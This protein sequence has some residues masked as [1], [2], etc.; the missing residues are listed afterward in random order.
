MLQEQ[1][2]TEIMTRF[3]KV[4]N[5]SEEDLVFPD[6]TQTVSEDIDEDV[7]VL[8][9]AAELVISTQFGSTSM[10][11][12]KL[13]IGF[14]KA[15]RLMDL[16]EE[17][18]IVGPSKGSKARD[19]LVKTSELQNALELLRHGASI[20]VSSAALNGHPEVAQ[21]E[22]ESPVDRISQIN[23]NYLRSSVSNNYRQ[24]RIQQVERILSDSQNN[25]TKF[26]FSILRRRER[27][28]EWNPNGLDIPLVPPTE[29]L[30][31]KPKSGLF[32]KKRLKAYEEV[33][34]STEYQYKIELKKYQDNESKRIA[35]LKKYI[36]EWERAK[37]KEHREVEEY[38]RALDAFQCSVR[39]G[40]RDAV[41]AFFSLLLLSAVY[42]RDIKVGH[43]VGYDPRIK[44]LCVEYLFPSI[45][46]VLPVKKNKYIKNNDSI[47][48]LREN[49]VFLKEMYSSVIAQI[50]LRVIDEIFRSDGYHNVETVAFNGV[51]H[52]TSPSTG[53][54][55]TAY[56]VS[57]ETTKAVFRE[58]DLRK[59][60]PTEALS[61]LYASVVSNP[62]ESE[63]I[64]PYMTMGMAEQLEKQ[65]SP[66]AGMNSVLNLMDLSP[67]EFER[68]IQKLFLAMGYIAKTT[69]ASGD[70]G[71]D[72]IAFDNTPVVG[73]KIVIQAKRYKGLVWV[74]AVRDLYG[75]LINEGAMKGILI[76][77]G[78]F[79]PAARKFIEDKP[80]ELVDGP[81]FLKLLEKH[82]GIK[83]QIV[84]PQNWVDGVMY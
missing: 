77:T 46:D 23:D 68:I 15:G 27:E 66:D 82:L 12:R 39:S 84:S 57:L 7:Q 32:L 21:V 31:S 34:S 78:H 14:T 18:Q 52:I 64:R 47:R 49:D 6:L 48:E 20:K 8:V 71:V 42:P 74:G 40:E 83:A 26:S 67:I 28:I 37:E 73:G 65:V 19:V 70:G 13:R 29:S 25:P 43:L 54:R 1:L 10:L 72:C 61:H 69:K 75:A 22:H 17:H 4:Q 5:I 9:E 3:K 45:G 11:Q 60:V 80:L 81:A 35:K 36:S 53:Q 50:T 55:E 44:K 2:I 58:L 41:S 62:L 38:N 24:F 63:S 76:T 30:P 56:L 16:L 79:G 33:K 51:R 59:V